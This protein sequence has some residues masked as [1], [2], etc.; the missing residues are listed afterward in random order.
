MDMDV[1]AADRPTYGPG[2]RAVT[3]EELKRIP[4]FKGT[5]FAGLSKTPPKGGPSQLEVMLA[6]YLKQFTMVDLDRGAVILRQGSYS[7]SAYLILS[8][9]V[10]IFLEGGEGPPQVARVPGGVPQRSGPSGGAS[11]ADPH[12]GRGMTSS[13]TIV[14]SDLSPGLGAGKRHIL[15]VGEIFGEINATS[16]CAASATVRAAARVRLLKMHWRAIKTL[17]SG[18]PFKPFADFLDARYRERALVAH[19][20]QAD[21]FSGLDDATLDALK[22]EVELARFERGETIAQEGEPADAFYMVRGGYVKVGVRLGTADVAV[23]YLRQGDYVGESALLVHEAWPFTLSALEYVELVKIP[24]PAFERILASQP[25]LWGQLWTTMTARLKERGRVL[26]DPLTTDAL[27]MAM[28]PRHH[29]GRAYPAPPQETQA[30]RAVREK[31]NAADPGRREEKEAGLIRGE[32]VLLIDLTTCTHCDDCVRGCASVHDGVPRFIREGERFRNWL[33]PTSCYQCL[34]PV[35]MMDCPTGAIS[36]DLD[37]TVT[38]N[39][40]LHP[41]RACIGCR[42]CEK[43]CPWGNIVMVPFES[44][45]VPETTERATKCDKCASRADRPGVPACVEM[46]PHGSA[47]RVSFRDVEQ[48]RRTFRD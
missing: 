45:Q 35:C 16:R 37:L 44:K 20:K 15:G 24:R 27:Q 11:V 3:V 26:R 9:G 22:S 1:E 30:K 47:V 28:E 36:R 48:L 6:K 34:D 18:A 23:T 46:C 14:L 10:E 40:P 41:T 4:L 32:S 43:N 31:D 13:G 38:I 5:L 8:G 2:E 17:T 29:P 42:K 39:G 21:V 25:D 33:I 7:D 19:L 12:L